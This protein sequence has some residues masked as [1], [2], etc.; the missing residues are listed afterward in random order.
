MQIT[1]LQVAEPDKDEFKRLKDLPEHE[2]RAPE[3]VH[4]A[5]YWPGSEA[6]GTKQL[7]QT[8]GVQRRDA[9]QNNTRQG[10]EQDEPFV[11]GFVKRADRAEGEV[12][13]YGDDCYPYPY[14]MEDMYEWYKDVAR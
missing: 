12:C 8:P 4:Q 2:R 3:I 13:A 14:P 11:H 9:H 7:A 5:E 1:Y 6:P 10:Q